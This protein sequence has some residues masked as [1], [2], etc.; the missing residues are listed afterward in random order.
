MKLITPTILEPGAASEEGSKGL[1]NIGILFV[2]S[3]GLDWMIVVLNKDITNLGTRS[4][5]DYEPQGYSWHGAAE[6][7]V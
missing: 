5:D 3:G 7:A 6:R 2:R 1:L 4:S